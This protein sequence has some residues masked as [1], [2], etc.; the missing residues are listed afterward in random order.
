MPVYY[1]NPYFCVNDIWILLSVSTLSL[2]LYRSLSN[3]HQHPICHI[4]TG[5]PGL[6]IWCPSHRHLPWPQS[7]LPNPLR[8]QAWLLYIAHLSWLI[9]C[10]LFSYS[11]SV[12]QTFSLVPGCWSVFPIYLLD[13][14][15]RK[16]QLLTR[17]SVKWTKRL[18]YVDLFR[19]TVG[20]DCDQL[21]LVG[22]HDFNVLTG[23]NRFQSDFL[24]IG[25][26]AI[27]WLHLHLCFPAVWSI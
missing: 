3:I 12:L 6:S 15:A 21:E 4:I 26:M 9:V 19:L 7:T 1:Y 20:P 18:T 5:L 11:H 27:E 24:E 17:G 8:P 10:Q 13:C 14:L 23:H 2:C 22:N 16:F 25:D